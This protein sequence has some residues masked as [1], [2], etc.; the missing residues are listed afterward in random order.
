MSI[1]KSKVATKSGATWYFTLY[2]VDLDGKRKK[3]KSKKYKLKEEAKRAETLFML[4]KES[5]SIERD[6]TVD[7]MYQLY[8]AE[9]EKE[10]KPQSVAKIR[11]LYKHIEPLIGLTNLKS[12]TKQ[13]YQNFKSKLGKDLSTVYKNKI[14]RL[15]LTI[16]DYAFKYYN[17]N[18]PAPRSVGP[19][20]NN[21][22]MKREQMFYTYEEY[23][24]FRNVLDTHVWVV[25]FDTLYFLGLR[26]NEANALT[27]ND[28]NFKTKTLKVNKTVVLKLKGIDF[29][30]SSPKTPSSIRTLPIPKKLLDGLKSLKQQFEKYPGFKNTWFVFGGPTPLGETTITNTKNRACKQAGLKQIRIHD[31]RHSCASLLINNGANITLVAK[32][33]GHSDIEMT[34]NTYSHMFDSKLNELTSMLDQF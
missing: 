17:I 20:K 34:L 9:K 24:Q 31:F 32:Y 10:I 26:K 19:F 29:R 4:S 27:W 11:N 2:Y 3:Y 21:N 12:L 6:V 13:Q 30:I 1:V 23:M 15:V 18:N 33:L 14:H 25:Y 28:I 7:D 8:I 22:E 16:F 5:R